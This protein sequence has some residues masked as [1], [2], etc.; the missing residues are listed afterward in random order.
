MQ[1]FIFGCVLMLCG[2]IGGTGWLTASA[3]LDFN[4]RW[5][6]AVDLFLYSG[7]D[8]FVALCFYIVAAA[9][10]LLALTSMDKEKK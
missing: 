8:G 10:L 7:I 5:I 1:K 3:S 9:G 4:G 6:S 2:V